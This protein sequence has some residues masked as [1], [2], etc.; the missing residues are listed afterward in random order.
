MLEELR[1]VREQIMRDRN[2]ELFEDSVEMIREM[3]EERSREL[4]QL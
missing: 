2:G 4:E 1:Q 3:R